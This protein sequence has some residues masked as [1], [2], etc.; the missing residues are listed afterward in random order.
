MPLPTKTLA[1]TSEAIELLAEAIASSIRW[2]DKFPEKIDPR[3][4][5]NI[6]A[7]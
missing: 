5:L 2:R 4:Y 6:A 3:Y 1:I 7:L